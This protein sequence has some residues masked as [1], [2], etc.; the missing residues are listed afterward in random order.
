MDAFTST[1]SSQIIRLDGLDGLPSIFSIPICYWYEN[2]ARS[3]WDNFM[4]PDL[5]ERAFY[6]TL[7]EFPIFSGHL[8]ADANSR[9]Y[10]E[11]DK[12]DLNMPVYTDTCCDLDYSAM[13]EAGF[14]IQKLPVGLR[15]EYRV[16]APPGLVGGQ[17]KSAHIRIV[18]F[19]DNSGVLVFATIAHYI[20][21]GYGYTQFMNRW[22]EIA[23]WMKHPEEAPMPTHL[24]TQDRAIHTSYRSDQTT[25]LD[26]LTIDSLSTK[27]AYT[28]WLSW[29]S[30]QTRGRY[31]RAMLGGSGHTCCFF[32]ISSKTMQD[33]RTAVQTCA[34]PQGTRFTANDVITAYVTIVVAQAMEKASAE[35]WSKPVPATIRKVLGKSFGKS[36]E[37]AAIIYVNMRW[38]INQPNIDKYMGNMAFGRAVPLS[39]NDV[40]D[41]PT[42]K[43]V[44]TLA[45]KINQAILATDEQFVGQFGQMLDNEPD[46]FMRLIISTTKIKNK[47]M[48]S[49]QSRFPHYS[50]DFGSGIPSM[51]RHA[52]HAFTDLAYVMPAHPETGGY[53]IEFNLMPEVALHVI[54][55]AAWMKLVDRYDLYL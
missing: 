25:A 45:Q 41:D 14:N 42:D 8:R 49:N 48:T 36:D 43:A 27:T 30:P 33:L 5:M 55:D 51:V 35:W 21:D 1:V 2:S 40:R 17:I 24:Y 28:K 20:F 13:Q 54:R 4:P 16:P 22:A 37:F 50:V 38:R 52:P 7:Q 6:K 11:I 26:A 29:I 12:D 32:H 34:P 9:M 31:F 39:K 15:E 47:L 19:K 53:E 3:S 23:R 10:V 18:R 46:N 44:S